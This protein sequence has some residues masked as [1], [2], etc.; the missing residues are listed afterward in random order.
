MRWGTAAIA[1]GDGTARQRWDSDSA[2]THMRQGKLRER[3]PWRAGPTWPRWKRGEQERAG[4]LHGLGQLD[5]FGPQRE[6]DFHFCQSFFQTTQKCNKSGEKYLGTSE[7]Y[8]KF[9]RGRF[10]YLAQLLYWALWL[11]VN[12]IQMKKEFRSG[13]EFG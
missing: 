8:E 2:A 3:N 13:L 1:T 9:S 6:N 4:L 12:Y 10:E 11:K 7:N 5:G